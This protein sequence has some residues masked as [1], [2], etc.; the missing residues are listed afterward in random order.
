MNNMKKLLTILIGCSLAL[1]ATAMAQ[2]EEAS[3]GK[4]KH[5]KGEQP[6]AQEAQPGMNQAQPRTKQARPG[7]EA[8]PANEAKPMQDRKAMRKQRP[9]ATAPAEI[10]PHSDMSA[11]APAPA[12]EMKRHGKNA[13]ANAN[14][15]RPGRQMKKERNA[16]DATNAAEKS[17]NPAPAS[18]NAETAPVVANRPGKK[19][20]GQAKK[21]D[22]QAV[23]QVKNRARQLQG[24]GEARESPGRHLQPRLHHQRSRPVAG[25]AVRSVSQLSPGHS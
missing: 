17:A 2:Q 6:P 14:E 7:R 25:A 20:K 13:N 18:T 3:P 10:N 8:R 15:M 5:Q 22:P 19:N 21:L 4:K 16:P 24:A 12:A 9:A 11:P 1:A 23:Q